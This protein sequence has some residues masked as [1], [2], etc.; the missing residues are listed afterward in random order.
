M[1]LDPEEVKQAKSSEVST[2]EEIIKI[3]AEINELETKIQKAINITKSYFFE[4][5][6]KTGKPLAK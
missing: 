4:K 5:L 1:Y 2:V 3:R 6:K